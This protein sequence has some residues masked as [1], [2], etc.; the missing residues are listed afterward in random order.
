MTTKK[1]DKSTVDAAIVG[2]EELLNSKSGA[3]W[4]KKTSPTYRAFQL[5]IYATLS[6]ISDEKTI[7][8]IPIRAYADTMFG[9]SKDD[10]FNSTTV[11]RCY[12]KLNE[13]LEQLFQSRSGFDA[14]TLR[15]IQPLIENVHQKIRAQDQ[16][17]H[18]SIH[19]S[20]NV[21]RELNK[22]FSE[23]SQTDQSDEMMIKKHGLIRNLISEL[24]RVARFVALSETDHD[25][26]KRFEEN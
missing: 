2:A 12:L 17:W 21:L 11:G 15:E 4:V 1:I 24:E 5:G 6:A 23:I 20:D 8:Q 9:S 10:S 25:L 14:S 13:T 19:R 16:N 7:N 18:T 3:S 26:W 22:V